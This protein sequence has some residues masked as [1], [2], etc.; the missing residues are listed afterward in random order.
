MGEPLHVQVASH[1]AT[2]AVT[3]LCVGV[4]MWL[5]QRRVPPSAVGLSYQRFV[6]ERQWWRALTAQVSHLDVLHLVLNVSS[7]WGLADQTEPEGVAGASL[8]YL[9]LSVLLL[10]TSAAICLALHHFAV[11]VLGAER[12]RHTLMVGYSCVLFGWM[13]AIAWRPRGQGNGGARFGLLGVASVPMAAAPFLLLLLTQLLL[14]HASFLGHL[15]GVLAGLLL[16]SGALDWIT[17][18][19]TACLLSWL[20]IG[21]CYGLALEGRL[22]TSYIRLLPYGGDSVIEDGSE[23]SRLVDLMERGGG[24]AGAGG[25][26]PG[27][28]NAAA[29]AGPVAAAAAA[30][31][32]AAVGAA[33]GL[34]A[35]VGPAASAAAAAAAQHVQG[36]AVWAQRRMQP[37]GTSGGW[38]GAAGPAA[39]G[40]ATGPGTGAGA[41]LALPWAN[42]GVSAGAGPGAGSVFVRSSSGAGPGG[43]GGVGLGTGGGPGGGA[44]SRGEPRP[45]WG[46][47]A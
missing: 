14:P 13:T 31:A 1:P 28:N 9:R 11:A 19:W 32:A 33:R 12:Q 5:L 27:E 25:A 16:A 43:L 44:T 41:G 18:Y 30:A 35:G 4:W 47:D 6:G 34:A 10:L 29:R 40:A 17:P 3:A 24:G 8:E 36:W 2:S 37:L 39:S 26:A 15:S 45:G 22:G 42:P 7:L 38:G 46:H 20:V 21:I 23:T